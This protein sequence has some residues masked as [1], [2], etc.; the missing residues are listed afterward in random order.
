MLRAA[1]YSREMTSGSGS[2]YYAKWI[3]ARNDFRRIR[4]ADH[5]IPASPEREYN[6]TIGRTCCDREIIISADMSEA[7]FAEQIAH[8]IEE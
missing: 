8:A 1:G 3:A 5:D 6:R 4:L 2:S 7:D